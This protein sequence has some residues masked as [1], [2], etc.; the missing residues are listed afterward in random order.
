[1]R[2]EAILFFQ[3]FVLFVRYLARN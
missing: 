2:G 1:V 3:G